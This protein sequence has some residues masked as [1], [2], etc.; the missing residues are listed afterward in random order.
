MATLVD[1]ATQEKISSVIGGVKNLPTPPIVFSQIQK[2][3][4]NPNASAFDIAAILQEDAAISA[5]V[6]K[7]TNSAYYGLTRT[8]ESVR[9]AV[10]IIGLEAVKNLV[11]SAS[12]FEA[13][14]K[15]Q[16]DQEFQDR[17]WRHS[18]ATAFAARML[19][20]N[21][22]CKFGFDAE[23]GFSAGLLH[24]IGKMVISVYMTDERLKIKSY[25]DENPDLTDMAIESEVLGYNHCQ[26][27]SL[28]GAQ[29]QLPGN[30]VEAVE[31]HHFPQ[32]TPTED[33]SVPYLTHLANYLATLAFDIDP[34]DE[35]ANIEPMQ[36][37]A[38]QNIGVTEQEIMGHVLPLREEYLKAETFMEMAKGVG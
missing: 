24:D 28:L 14:S 6:L 25:K 27:G 21:L 13:F 23:A 5:K 30:L 3:M 11:L 4:N 37:D 18:L 31:F 15:D 36:A 35:K 16:I 38:L 2:V 32:T 12:V 29:W 8:I 9:Q 20:R 10:V 7:M 1:S 17:F 22:K 19:A 33:N 34:D 26:I